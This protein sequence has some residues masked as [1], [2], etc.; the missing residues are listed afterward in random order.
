[1][2]DIIQRVLLENREK[3]L[4]NFIFNDLIKTQLVFSRNLNDGEP[5]VQFRF[6]ITDEPGDEP[7]YFDIIDIDKH[8]WDNL[9]FNASMDED[10]WDDNFIKTIKSLYGVDDEKTIKKVFDKMVSYVRKEL[11]E[12]KYE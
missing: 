5:F 3:K 2:K 9:N 4:F 7:Q 11:R 8:W 6:D 1:M 10:A 12:M